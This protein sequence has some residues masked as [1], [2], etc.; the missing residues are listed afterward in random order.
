[1]GMPGPRCLI[2]PIKEMYSEVN[3]GHLN[4]EAFLSEVKKIDSSQFESLL[5]D[6]TI[7]QK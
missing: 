7:A 4:A 2:F 3:N 1:M 6:I 5:G